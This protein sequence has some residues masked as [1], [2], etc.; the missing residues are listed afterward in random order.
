MKRLDNRSNGIIENGSND[1]ISN[2]ILGFI[3]KI[4]PFLF[5][6]VFLGIYIYKPLYLIFAFPEY[7]HPGNSTDKFEWLIAQIVITSISICF[8]VVSGSVILNEKTDIKNRKIEIIFV[9]SL[10]L[11]VFV[12]IFINEL[13]LFT[14]IVTF[15]NAYVRGGAYGMI[16]KGAI[17]DNIQMYLS[18]WTNNRGIVL[19]LG[20]L[21]YIAKIINIPYRVLW[22]LMDSLM[23]T[24]SILFVYLTVKMF[25]NRRLSLILLILS[26]GF[27]VF[28]SCVT[29]LTNTGGDWYMLYTDSTSMFFTTISTYFFVR[30]FLENKNDQKRYLLLSF[31][32]IAS[33][34]GAVFKPTALI[35]LL[36]FF[37]V[38]LLNRM[39]KAK[40]KEHLKSVLKHMTLVVLSVCLIIT[41]FEIVYDHFETITDPQRSTGLLSHMFIL[42]M[43]NTGQ[44]INHDGVMVIDDPPSLNPFQDRGRWNYAESEFPKAEVIKE[45]I[46][47]QNIAL[48]GFYY[49][50]DVNNLSFTYEPSV[51]ELL[52]SYHPES[53]YKT[54]FLEEWKTVLLDNQIFVR[55]VLWNIILFGIGIWAYIILKK[56]T[57]FFPLEL[58][59]SIAMLGVFIYLTFFE[60]GDRYVMQFWPLFLVVSGLGFMR[61]EKKLKIVR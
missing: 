17:S 44:N 10:I 19:F 11:S 8:M 15:D 25:C 36:A 35:I 46:K 38:L 49:L 3:G 7:T 34:M 16:E 45:R 20:F 26:S 4:F 2:P 29:P 12:I 42:G 31:G 59:L 30:F 55:A 23:I 24:S 39:S 1:L 37:P 41:S 48:V 33:A 28:S 18:Q 9:S 61:L 13:S 47:Q 58:F 32:S 21:G 57:K 53:Y 43:L 60:S 5:I 6:L 14:D 40:I 56:K 50:K 27:L 51:K 54:P 22:I 52:V